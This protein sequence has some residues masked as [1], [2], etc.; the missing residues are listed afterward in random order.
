MPSTRKS[1][2]SSQL[3]KPE[4]MAKAVRCVAQWRA[5][6]QDGLQL[7][8]PVCGAQGLSVADQSARPITE[9]YRL[10]CRSCGLNEAVAIPLAAPAN[11]LGE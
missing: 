5:N 8:C 2:K 6:P 9:W 11:P 7:E 4:V 1:P 10:S 3:A